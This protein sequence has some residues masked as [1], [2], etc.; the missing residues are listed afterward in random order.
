MSTLAQRLS[1]A[2]SELSNKSQAD[3]ARA[4]GVTSPSVNGG[5]FYACSEL[6]FATSSPATVAQT[7]QTNKL[8]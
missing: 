4:C 6:K 1:E 8:G 3:L 2:L 5:F 7:I